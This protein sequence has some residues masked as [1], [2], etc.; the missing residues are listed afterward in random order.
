MRRE[1]LPGVLWVAASAR[2]DQSMSQSRSQWFS[3]GINCC[4]RRR[5]PWSIASCP[6]VTH[7]VYANPSL[8]ERDSHD[9]PK[10]SRPPSIGKPRPVIHSL[11]EYLA[12][13]GRLS[14][15]VRHTAV[16]KP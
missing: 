15:S 9:G 14:K 16:R 3:R 2:V 6:V 13:I 10:I 4:P 5:H 1:L 8:M 11:A 7:L 12:V